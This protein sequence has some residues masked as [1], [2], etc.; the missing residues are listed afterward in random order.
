[1]LTLGVKK[2]RE[3]Q[4]GRGNSDRK[5]IYGISSKKEV[6]GEFCPCS[7]EKGKTQM[8]FS[9]IKACCEQGTIQTKKE[10]PS[11]KLART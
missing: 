2:Q 10:D 9:R 8:I 11:L 6:M 5:F 7:Q 4:P 1:M 3:V